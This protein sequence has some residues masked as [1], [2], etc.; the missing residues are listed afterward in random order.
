MS[1]KEFIIF[2]CNADIIEALDYPGRECF[3]GTY[4]LCT[5]PQIFNWVK[6]EVFAETVNSIYFNKLPELLT[7]YIQATSLSTR[8]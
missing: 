2:L 7:L 5:R 1:D 4:T 8:E 3:H 6:I